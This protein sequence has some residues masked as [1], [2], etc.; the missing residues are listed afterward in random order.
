[1]GLY[2]G[3]PPSLSKLGIHCD[4]VSGRDLLCGEGVDGGDGSLECG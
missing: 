4:A 1:M 2:I 3:L